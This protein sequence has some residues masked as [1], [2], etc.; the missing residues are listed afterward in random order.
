MLKYSKTNALKYQIIDE[1]IEK[2]EY[3]KALR[4]LNSIMQENPDIQAIKLAYKLHSKLVSYVGIADDL[5]KMLVSNDAEAIMVGARGLIEF[6]RNHN[7]NADCYYNFAAKKLKP[8]IDAN[9]KEVFDQLLGFSD[10]KS[11][12]HFVEKPNKTLKIIEKIDKLMNDGDFGA[13]SQIA[14]QSASEDASLITK[15][16]IE[17]LLIEK[18]YKEAFAQIKKIK[19]DDEDTYFK[20][21]KFRTQYKL[22]QTNESSISELTG[23]EIKFPEEIIFVVEALFDAKKPEIVIDFIE[24]Y[25]EKFE[26]YYPMHFAKGIAYLNLK[27][28]KQAEKSFK[29]AYILNPRQVA[30]KEMYLMLEKGK[31]FAGKIS[32]HGRFPKEVLI[33]IDKKY[34]SIMQLSDLEFC[35]LSIGKIEE[36]LYWLEMMHSE[37]TIEQYLLRLICC[38]NG[39]E[40]IKGILLSFQTSDWLKQQCIKMLVFS[41]ANDVNIYYTISNNLKSVN[42]LLPTVIENESEVSETGYYSENISYEKVMYAYAEA[43]SQLAMESEKFEDR[44]QEVA[45]YL[46]NT[47]MELYPK[48]KSDKI[49]TKLIVA[50]M[51]YCT[52][53]DAAGTTFASEKANNKSFTTFS[54]TA[55]RLDLPEEELKKFVKQIF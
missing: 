6:A 55:T 47:I 43:Y 29:N 15:M 52:C 10:K 40:A 54:T 26:F 11:T 53:S 4:L 25:E 34:K 5:V 31:K 2:K 50:A 19:K 20:C 39:V 18:K 30:A 44:L 27:N 8:F 12:F 14:Q 41:G 24:K 33:E 1:S 9:S 38:K 51:L 23:I 16:S 17:S 35:K 45:S 36:M 21:L 49:P 7:Q 3:W 22:K 32:I 37:K 42:L 28:C 46:I 13:A 48:Q